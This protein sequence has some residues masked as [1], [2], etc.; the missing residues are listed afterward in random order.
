MNKILCNFWWMWLNHEWRKVHSTPE[1][2]AM[3]C[4]GAIFE[5]IRAIERSG[6]A[7]EE[8][9]YAYST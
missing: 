6:V 4:G 2:S 8:R 9:N 5:F 7:L 1:Q 3:Y